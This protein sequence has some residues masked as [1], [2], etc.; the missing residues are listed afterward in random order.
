MKRLKLLII[1]LFPLLIYSQVN[2]F[3]APLY[4][5]YDPL[6]YNASD[7]NWAVVQDKRGV[8]Y[9]GNN[10]EGVLEYDGVSWQKIPVSN[11]TT[12]RSLA[13]NNMGVV[14]VG[15]VG[16]FGYL[17]PDNKGKLHYVSLSVKLDTAQ[18]QFDNVYK[19][20]PNGDEVY[21]CT[22]HE[23]F[24]YKNKTL[25][26][27]AKLPDA[28]FM[29]FFIDGVFYIG[30]YLQGLIKI[31]TRDS[32]ISAPGGNFF[33]RR[34]IISI[35]PYD[36]KHY[37]IG[38]VE[39]GMFIYDKNSG[40]I[41]DT[42][43]SDYAKDFLTSNGLYSSE[44]IEKT[45]EYVLGTLNSG[46]IVINKNGHALNEFTK[47]IG[48]QDDRAYYTYSSSDSMSLNPVWLALDKGISKLYYNYPLKYFGETSGL[49]G[50]VL[51]VIRFKNVL[52]VSTVYG[53][54]Y[55]DF[56]NNTPV[57]RQI[58][59]IQSAPWKFAKMTINKNEEI[60]LVGT[61]IGLYKITNIKHAEN[62]EEKILNLD[63]KGKKYYIF[64]LHEST[65]E[66]N[67][68]FLGTNIGVLSL[69]YKNNSWEIADDFTS[70]I[71]SEIRSITE[72]HQGNLWLATAFD[73]VYKIDF[74]TKEITK[75]GTESG[76]PSLNSNFVYNFDN[77]LFFAT[78]FGIWR[79]KDKENKFYP[80]STFGPSY[81]N[82][83]EKA[84]HFVS[85][86]QYGNY[87]LSL[88]NNDPKRW[89]EIISPYDNRT[90]IINDIPFK[91]LPNLV[92]EVIYEDIEGYVWI[93]NSSGMYCY[94]RNFNRS[95]S[96]DYHALIR[97]VTV[98]EDSVIFFGT[99]YSIN[100]DSMLIPSFVQTLDLKPRLDY[101]HRNPVFYFSAPYFDEENAIEF[102][103]FLEGYSESWSKWSNEPRAVFTNLPEGDYT[104][105][106]KAKN[107]YGFESQEASYSF[108]I[109]PPWYR[110]IWAYIAYVI[111]GGALLIIIIKL[112]TR[113]LTRDK[114]RLEQIV[115][116]R[117]AEVVAQKEELQLQKDKIAEINEELT[118]SILYAK[119]IQRAIL[120]HEEFAASILSEH[121]ILFKPKDI[122][123]GDFFWLTKIDNFTIVTA[124]DC[125][126]HGVPGAFMSMLGV[127]FLNEIVKNK[128]VRTTGQVLD[129]LREH[130]IK[131]LQQT[132]KSGE[133]KDGMDISLVAI[134]NKTNI[135]Q[136][137]GAN[138]PLYLIRSKENGTSLPVTVKGETIFLETVIEHDKLNLFELKGDKMPVAIHIVMDNFTS[139]EIQLE[140]GD[141]I[142][143]FSDGF[144][145]QFGGAKGK[146]FMYKPFKN[147]ILSMQDKPMPEQKIILDTSIEEW[148]SH[149]NPYSGHAFEQID[150]IVVVGLK[151]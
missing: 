70:D 135:M 149:T 111:V 144:A 5:N 116:E 118:D 60:L 80:D 17:S 109:L 30:N 58:E 137:S 55:Q 40:E 9:F 24:C 112:Y 48:L 19:I 28:S 56:E 84:I 88:S 6:L 130:I 104:F 99:Y 92:I 1:F 89:M 23:I 35:N 139:N 120:P 65:F 31:D 136:F 2:K 110:T 124:A 49:K 127:A 51:D 52:Y 142:Y 105:K 108:S 62:I 119:R 123:S 69:E 66:E 16:E 148:K 87:W 29:S 90:Y 39:S 71:N 36:E 103:Y 125:T 100:D 68:V 128:N 106:V 38:T 20:Y 44:Y 13:V 113:K 79:F 81:V 107:I 133:Q 140:K 18:N 93:G 11:K 143:L 32:I 4:Q 8:M 73:G 25:S 129:H 14:F 37:L 76:L 145:D 26:K 61:S 97:K 83:D 134:D 77:K 98:G 33:A 46:A 126:G 45:K 43:L 21:F 47:S 101:K 146:K 117:T 85:R 94:D 7:Q 67:K 122:V 151:I 12:V 10:D 53:V 34:N 150:D 22:V 147:L 95:Y 132:G 72:D 121:F 75:F 138:N 59:E 96:D 64:C 42:L 115:T 74:K 114:I 54:Y 82:S 102:Q 141:A 131:S 50:G 27:F 41:S 57:F 63:P 78:L 15:A 86:D 3:G 91:P